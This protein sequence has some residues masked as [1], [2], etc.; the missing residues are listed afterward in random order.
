MPYLNTYKL[1]NLI[2]MNKIKIILL[3]L[4]CS[5]ISACQ[6]DVDNMSAYKNESISYF[7]NSMLTGDGAEGIM[8]LA[9]ETPNPYTLENMQAALIELQN[10]NSLGCDASIFNIRVTHKYIRFEPQDSIQMGLLIQDTTLILFDYPLDRKIIKGGTYYRDPAV[11][12]GQPN[13]QWTCV[14][15]QKDLPQGVPYVVISDLY[16]PEEDENLVQYYDTEIDGSINLLIEEALRRTGNLD[17]TNYYGGVTDGDDKSTFGW[18]SKWT[19][20]GRIRLTDNVLNNISG[21][22]GV[23]VKVH[24]WFEVRECLTNR[25]G[26]FNILH[27]F[28][29]PVNYSIKWERNDFQI[30]S[31]SFGQAYFNGPYKNGDWNLD[32]VNGISWHY[33]HVHRAAID[34]YYNNPTSLRR[35]PLNGF[36][37]MRLTFG[38]YDECDRADYRHWQRLW[39]G[40]EI[41]MYSKWNSC[42]A[43]SSQDQYRTAIHEL[44]HASHFNMS[45]WHFRNSANMMQE[46]W[47]VGVAWVFEI[48]KYPNP[49]DLQ[50]LMLQNAPL[51]NGVR[52]D[53][54]NWGERQYTPLVIDLIDDINQRAN[55]KSNN[56]G[57]AD[58]PI[59]N[60]SSYNIRTIEDALNT[61]ITME[62]WRDAL[63]NSKPS[64]I[65]NA[66]V[67]ELFS[68]YI[69][70]Q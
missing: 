4:I 9:P 6:K 46:S 17:T 68:N 70:L 12:E 11:P 55:Q 40:P 64:G 18:P 14:S 54:I 49:I 24:R 10:L 60:V 26:D 41:R 57:N 13:Y 33:G 66:Q 42:D 25:S 7:S 1:K 62:A 39:F 58:F 16:L 34:Y 31:G 21:L 36:L 20:K 45:H 15:V 23:K 37:G 22:N 3:V 30:R 52:F 51:I 65:S 63:K 61:R 47:A 56:G 19:P 53:V 32:I 5:I 67:D 28:R 69:P 48:L 50:N 59:D 38:V 8:E 2:K 27:K 29:Y 43:R 44:A 35:P